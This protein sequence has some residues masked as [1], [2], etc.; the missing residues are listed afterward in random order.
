MNKLLKTLNLLLILLFAAI[1]DNI[2]IA[3]AK[4]EDNKPVRERLLMDYGW[5]FALGHTYDTEKDF[6]HAT[7]YF[8]Y[9]VKA[10]Y[11]DGAA[12]KDFDDRS[13]RKINLPH[14]WCVELPFDST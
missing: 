9:F 10:G 6:D 13:W 1:F 2:I 3:Q 14:D 5:R 7:S 8:S 4:T 12:A 11:G